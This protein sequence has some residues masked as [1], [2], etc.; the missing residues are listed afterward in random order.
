MSP[1]K[2]FDLYSSLRRKNKA[3]FDG[4]PKDW[5]L[6][7]PYQDYWDRFEFFVKKYYQDSFPKDLIIALNP[8]R[9]GCN[10]TGIALTDEKIL[11]TKLN[12]LELIP[13][14]EEENTAQRVYQIIE[15]VFPKDIH[16]FFSCY[17]LTNVFPFGVISQSKNNRTKNVDFCELIEIKSINDFSK[18]FIKKSI[19]VFNPRRILCVGKKSKDFIDKNFPQYVTKYLWHPSRKFPES[20]KEKWRYALRQ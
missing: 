18:D 10:K 20:E 12:Y 11:K 6:V 4:F 3:D 14:P 2:I 19:E 17:F 8:G 9:K 5:T 1:K 16:K 7:N 15:E 13:E